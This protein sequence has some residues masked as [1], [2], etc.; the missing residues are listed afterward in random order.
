[1]RF[2][3]LAIAATLSAAAAA[4]DA[5]T[6]A[7]AAPTTA[8]AAAPAAATAAAA[9]PATMPVA[10]DWFG[11]AARPATTPVGQESE[12]QIFARLYPN[13]ANVDK[14]TREALPR[15]LFDAMGTRG[16]PPLK[17]PPMHNLA[18]PFTDASA[19]AHAQSKPLNPWL[20]VPDERKARIGA[21]GARQAG[22]SVFLDIEA[23]PLD[24]RTHSAADID[25]SIR[26][27]ARSV[28]WVRAQD[29]NTRLYFY[30][31]FPVGENYIGPQIAHIARAR[32]G[33]PGYEYWRNYAPTAEAHH[34]QWRDAN[35]YLGR[36]REPGVEGSTP[37]LAE[38][39][40]GC[41]PSLYLYNLPELTDPKVAIPGFVR[42]TVNEAR[43]YGKPVY[44]FVWYAFADANALLPLPLWTTLMRE[45]LTHADGAVL[46]DWEKNSWNN[47]HALRVRIAML[48][49]ERRG[50]M[51][52][53]ELHEALKADY[54]GDTELTGLRGEPA[55]TQ[56]T[57]QNTTQ[58]TT[59]QSR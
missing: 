39:F 28:G 38:L 2:R 24:R 20:L 17:L 34:K 30:G 59:Q 45:V 9:A 13:L 47:R 12:A 41:C 48:L 43:R 27:I 35:A 15:L 7:P 33:M 57:T 3:W 50:A 1:M 52:D 36:P 4:Q 31:G 10:G 42:E 19:R 37:V 51:T 23:L 11:G 29:P 49:A 25:R 14:A 46:W 8:P 32:P 58:N 53:A 26:V 6:T 21:V 16:K 18:H 44:P 22:A 40:D 56:S 5:P 55:T 54:P